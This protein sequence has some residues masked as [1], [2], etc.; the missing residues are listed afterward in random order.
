MTRLIY[1]P[2]SCHTQGL[3]RGFPV[4]PN[5]AHD[6]HLVGDGAHCEEPGLCGGLL[7]PAKFHL[8]HMRRRGRVTQPGIGYRV[9]AQQF[10]KTGITYLLSSAHPSPQSHLPF[11][12]ILSKSNLGSRAI[13]GLAESAFCIQN[14]SSY[15]VNVAMKYNTV[16]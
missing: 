4:F 2:A 8:L 1:L 15:H 13:W 9:P 3:K 7:L 10:G 11:S 6:P 14:I 5:S 16:F 12:R